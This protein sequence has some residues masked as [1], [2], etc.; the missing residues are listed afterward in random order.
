MFF[1]K[2]LNYSAICNVSLLFPDDLG[3]QYEQSEQVVILSLVFWANSYLY[4]T[5]KIINLKFF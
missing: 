4:R 1:L 3:L 2:K 5:L